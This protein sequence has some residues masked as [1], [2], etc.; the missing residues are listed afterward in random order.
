MPNTFSII[1]TIKFTL[2]IVVYRSLMLM[3]MSKS[4]LD[5][6]PPLQGLSQRQL[7]ELMGWDY[8]QF[9]Q[10]AKERGLSTHVYMQQQTGWTLRS[11]LYYPP[12]D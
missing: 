3:N 8:R 10:T 5:D 9:A 4:N 2:G 12:V 11:E 7:C 1:E 6:F